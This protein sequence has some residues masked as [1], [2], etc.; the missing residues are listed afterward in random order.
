MADRRL[1]R[2]LL[3][4]FLQTWLYITHYCA[5]DWPKPRL[6][7]SSYST[8]MKHSRWSQSQTTTVVVKVDHDDLSL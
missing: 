3:I 2:N 6:R 8:W 5:L 7:T 1:L 4:T